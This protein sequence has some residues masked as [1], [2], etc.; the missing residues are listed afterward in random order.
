MDNFV[1]WAWE[2]KQTIWCLLHHLK[3][4][5]KKHLLMHGDIYGPF[6]AKS[7]GVT[8]Y[9]IIFIDDKNRMMWIKSF[10][11]KDQALKVFEEFE[12]FVELETRK[13]IRILRFDDEGEFKFEKFIE[14]SN[15]EGVRRESM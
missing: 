9:F 14:F 1:T 3:K 7:I 12:S 8:K 6:I 10:K 13:R 15:Q 2:N 4:I 11:S 5:T